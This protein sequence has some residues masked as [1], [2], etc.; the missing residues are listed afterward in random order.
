MVP[1]KDTNPFPTF[2]VNRERKRLSPVTARFSP[3]IDAVERAER[4]GAQ[5]YLNK[6]I[7]LQ[8]LLEIINEYA[9]G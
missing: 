8:T 3:A 2:G 4:A 9:P 1:A 6:P 7:R 5:A